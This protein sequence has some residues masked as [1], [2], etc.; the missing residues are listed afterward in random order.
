M[1]FECARTAGSPV[2]YRPVPSNCKSQNVP[3]PQV[4]A[5]ARRA[6]PAPVG[7]VISTFP[8]VALNFACKLGNLV[9]ARDSPKLQIF[10]ALRADSRKA[11]WS[12][13]QTGNLCV[14]PD[15][16]MLVFVLVCLCAFESFCAAPL[17]R[18][19]PADRYARLARRSRQRKY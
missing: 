7:P 8:I 9:L 18:F 3:V 16:R 13:M 11:P 6:L 14:P 12:R 15:T 1:N 19:L 2:A 17:L 10:H 5:G 4:L